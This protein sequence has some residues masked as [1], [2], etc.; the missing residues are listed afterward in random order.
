MRVIGRRLVEEL[1]F[2]RALQVVVRHLL[3]LLLL[4]AVLLRGQ[5]LALDWFRMVGSVLGTD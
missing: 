5:D 1:L 4:P 3:L 2:G